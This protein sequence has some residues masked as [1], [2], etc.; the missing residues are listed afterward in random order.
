MKRMIAR[1][2]TPSISSSV[3]ITDRLLDAND[4]R[5]DLSHV[6]IYTRNELQANDQ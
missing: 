1:S 2:V 6:F 5:L 3:D 4:G